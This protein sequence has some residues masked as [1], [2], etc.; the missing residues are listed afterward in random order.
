MKVTRNKRVSVKLATGRS[1][2]VGSFVR[3]IALPQG[4]QTLHRES[5]SVFR[6]IL[7]Y[8]FRVAA[9]TSEEPRWLEL[10]VGRVVDEPPHSVG[11]VVWLETECVE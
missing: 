11:N 9:I 8:R 10:Q 7:G 5:R 6:A 1:V 4:F 2:R 3:V